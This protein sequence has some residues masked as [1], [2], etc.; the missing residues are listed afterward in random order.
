M[1]KRTATLIVDDND[2]TMFFVNSNKGWKL[3]IIADAIVDGNDN[4]IIDQ[5]PALAVRVRQAYQELHKA[6]E[7][8]NHG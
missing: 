8:D 6:L 3:V 1:E 7:G 4:P 2:A 5:S